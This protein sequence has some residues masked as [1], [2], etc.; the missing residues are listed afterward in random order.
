MSTAADDELIDRLARLETGQ[1][2]DVLDEAGLPDHALSVDILPLAPGQRLVGR[3]ACVRGAPMTQ[4]GNP[5]TGLPADTLERVATAGSVLVIESGGFTA[6]ALLGGFVAYSLRRSGCTG[7]VTDGAIRDA[8]EIR[9]YGMP[10]YARAVTPLNGS[11]RWRLVE[12]DVPIALSGQTGPAVRIAPGDLILGDGDGVV[13][14]PQAA[15]E[16]IIED[17]EELARIEGRIGDALRGGDARTAVF[18][19]HPRFAHVRSADR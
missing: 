19:R 8:D 12:A 13:V 5:R 4:T 11:R 18:K 16:T 17:A 14:I 6:G 3:A 2:S 1:V 9:S 15:A 7:I 10:C